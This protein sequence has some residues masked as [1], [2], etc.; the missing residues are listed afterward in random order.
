ML[1]LLFIIGV[2]LLVILVSKKEPQGTRAQHIRENDQQWMDYLEYTKNTTTKPAEKAV[3]GKLIHEL[4]ANG[5]PTP[6]QNL[7][8]EP[9]AKEQIVA[10]ATTEPPYV[11]ALPAD[12]ADIISLWDEQVPKP[13]KANADLDSETLLLYFGSFLF[14][15]AAGLFVG[16]GTANGSVRLGVV[17][18][19]MALMYTGGLWL[20]RNRPK[21]KIAGLTFVG[22]GLMLAP[23][24]GVA[25]YSFLFKDQPEVVWFVTSVLC[26]GL[27]AHALRVLK[28]PLLEY[29]FLG[30]FLSLFESIL[31]VLDAP[32][33]YFGWMLAAFGL[34]LQA[35]GIWRSW[36]LSPEQPTV[37]SSQLLLP[38][39]V[40]VALFLT[41][42]YG[43]V[44]LAVS[45]TLA[46]TY[47]LLSA[48]RASGI[49]RESYAVASHVLYLG[50][51]SLFAY[52]YQN[53]W[54][55]V[56]LALLV[57]GGIQTIAYMAV[58]VTSI[59]YMSATITMATLIAAT[60]FAW[61]EP[62]L[63]L[64]SALLVVV[65]SASLWLRQ[66]RADAYVLAAWALAVIPVIYA[67]QIASPIVTTHT[68]AWL[69]TGTLFI[70]LATI[71]ATR[72]QTGQMANW[73][74]NMQLAYLSVLGVTAVVALIDGSWSALAICIVLACSTIALTEYD[75]RNLWLTVGGVT[76]FL[77][78]FVVWPN[79]AVFLAATVIGLFW[80]IALALKYRL[81]VN[82]W[83]GT[84]HW[85][86]LPVGLA[87]MWPDQLSNAEYFAL[88]YVGIVAGLLV[89]RAIAT[90][91]VLQSQKVPVISY[92]QT[93]SVSYVVGYV[94]ASTIALGA[95]V[96]GP[97]WLAVAVALVLAVLAY[98]TSLKIERYPDG[99]AVIPLILQIGLWGSFDPGDSV[100]GYV[101]LS[102]GLAV[103]SYLVARAQKDAEGLLNTRALLQASCVMAYVA[104]LSAMA[105]ETTWAM[106][107]GLFI[108]GAV[109]LDAAWQQPQANRELAGGVLVLSV[110]WWMNYAG[111]DNIQAYTHVIAAA[112]GLYAYWRATRG[113]KEVS[114]QYIVWMLVVASVPLALQAMSGQG[115]GM[116]GWWFLLEQVA[117]MLLGISINNSFV[118][119]WGL[120]AS[121]LAV[122][123]QLRNLGWAALTVL[124]IFIIGMALYRLQRVGDSKSTTP[125]PDA[126][127][128]DS[129]S[130]KRDN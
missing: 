63:M 116:Y 6:H 35:L 27:Y 88:A 107:L 25:A 102:T 71:F 41:P 126:I 13:P 81:D 77:P 82:R 23:L 16:F 105:I 125:E 20:Y 69:L 22:I 58:R 129:H 5:M 122:L 49:S 91:R 96:F 74:T 18:A 123:Y 11:A 124:A 19:V 66:V 10:Q 73:H 117:I 8:A 44:Q 31:S 9:V 46:G 89:A 28:N 99:L 86:L 59:T 50:A 75:D 97:R 72:R 84:I 92:L 32:V 93:A 113:E 33:Y 78:L 121:V 4:L 30:T 29:V 36:K 90:G 14:V 47:Y 65:T 98:V 103:G 12:E 42:E 115:G 101:L 85:L 70:Q 53:E 83:L 112:L 76:V 2:I 80:N 55:H 1:T 3:L 45:A 43:Y 108:A 62:V 61:Q 95:S 67:L 118:I 87:H 37:V 119:R 110:L 120:Y 15:A 51:V 64:A 130:V 106:P 79:P 38:A 48:I 68:I 26:L 114:Q 21:L 24:A 34:A 56:T 7:S 52:A 17:L 128:L 57:V 111:I 60:V 39:A 104:P 100:G 54:Q 127:K 40:I 109:T 94:F